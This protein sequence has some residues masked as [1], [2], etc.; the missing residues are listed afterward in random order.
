MVSPSARQ[1]WGRP[2]RMPRQVLM[3]Q[4]CTHLPTRPTLA[5]L[6]GYGRAGIE[7]ASGAW[8]PS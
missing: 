3:T 6:T 2:T 5:W 7:P 1:A 4:P 8:R